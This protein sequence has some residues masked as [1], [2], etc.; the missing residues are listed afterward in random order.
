MYKRQD[1]DRI[2]LE[3]YCNGAAERLG[4]KEYQIL[5]L[6]MEQPNRPLSAERLMDLVWGADSEADVSVVWVYISNLR[7]RLSA[8]GSHVV[9]RAVRGAG[10]TLEVSDE[11]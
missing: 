5:E 7:K 11:G 1:L 4:N 6:L 10:Y 2:T 8:M 3:L 9:I